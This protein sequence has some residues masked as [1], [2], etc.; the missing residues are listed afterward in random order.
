MSEKVQVGVI[1]I[2]EFGSLHAEIYS[3]LQS[4]ELVAVADIDEARLEK[5]TASHRCAKYKDF[6]D[7]VERDD[8]EAISVC[9][10]DN[11]HVESAVAAASSGKHILVEKP[12]AKTVE[13]CDKIITAANETG[14]K[15]MVGQIF[16]F[17]PRYHTAHKAVREGKIGEIV[18]FWSRHNA[19][20]CGARKRANRTSALFILGLHGLDFM[21]WCTDSKVERVYAESI[22]KVL[23]DTLESEDTYL[24]LIKY[25]NGVIGSLESSWVLP[26]NYPGWVDV[27]LEIMGTKGVIFIDNSGREFEIVQGKGIEYPNM[28]TVV[29][30]GSKLLGPLRHE[31]EHFIECIQ[32]DEQPCVSGE[33]GKAAV[34]VACAIE[35]SLERQEPV[36]MG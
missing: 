14:V 4:T 6:H 18:H 7:L 33:D 29:P 21:N 31:I 26:E 13:D 9:T 15:L 17:D 20:V 2:G 8:I 16:R 1:G 12:L 24:A 10:P 22:R 30:V 25:K 32:K 27:R 36:Y 19:R 28:R 34:E 35:K 3:Q 5:F 11:L 23:P